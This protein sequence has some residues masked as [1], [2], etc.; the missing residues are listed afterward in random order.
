MWCPNNTTMVSNI[1][2]KLGFSDGEGKIYEAIMYSDHATLQYIH[3]QTGI[4]RRN[5]YD[6]INKLIFKGLVTYINE[7]KHKV[8][9]VT[10]P[11]KLFEYFEREKKQIEQNQ[12]LIL[13]ELPKLQKIYEKTKPKLDARI[14]RGKEGVRSLFIELLDSKDIYF[15][16]GNWGFNKYLGRLWVENWDKKRV[17]NKV[18]WHDIIT[19]PSKFISDPPKHKLKFYAAKHLPKDFNSPNVFC[20]TNNIAINLYWGEPLLAVVIEN[21]EV[22]KNYI[23]YYNYLWK[24]LK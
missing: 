4:E 15:I 6:I 18:K 3:E 8:Y 14:Y 16:G 13:D 21:Q 17:K 24:Q 22:A 2:S 5:V 11:K 9:R 19:H 23:T 20:M 7:N 12:Q 10:N 1:W